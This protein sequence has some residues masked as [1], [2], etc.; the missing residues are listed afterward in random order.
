[1]ANLEGIFEKPWKILA[2]AVSTCVALLVGF[3]R[4]LAALSLELRFAIVG[5]LCLGAE[6]F[7]AEVLAF[8]RAKS[9]GFSKKSNAAPTPMSKIL[10]IVVL[11]GIAAASVL[12]LLQIVNFHN[13]RIL[14]RIDP[15]DSSVGIVEVQPSHRAIKL[16]LIMSTPQDGP[17]IL[18]KHP[19]SWNRED[20]VQWRMQNDSPSG[21]TLILLDFTSPKVFGMWYQL[22][23]NATEL[24]ISERTDPAEI[25]VLRENQLDRFRLWIWMFGGALCAVGLFFWSFRSN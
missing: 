16:T 11:V 22:S 21:V 8:K 4:D 13:I 14:Q 19:G 12:L 5:I 15:H 3:E 6:L 25:R 24:R 2:A 20:D 23:G 17:Q 7:V 18:E 1:M 9:V 10:S